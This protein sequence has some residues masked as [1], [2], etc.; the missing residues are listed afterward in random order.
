M[1]KDEKNHKSNSFFTVLHFLKYCFD[2]IFLKKFSYIYNFLIENNNAVIFGM[3]WK[4]RCLHIMMF[5]KNMRF[6]SC[7][8]IGLWY[9]GRATANYGIYRTV[10]K[11]HSRLFFSSILQNNKQH[12][13][14]GISVIHAIHAPKFSSPAICLSLSAQKN[15]CKQLGKKIRIVEFSQLGLFFLFFSVSKNRKR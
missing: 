7:G 15:R 1:R 3:T 8:S 13:Q 14:Q 12:H 10:Q 5:Q 11:S 6:T 9:R 4:L 2:S